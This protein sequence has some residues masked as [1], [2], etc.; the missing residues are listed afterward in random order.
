MCLRMH[1]QRFIQRL[2][3]TA[4]AWA[5]PLSQFLSQ[6]SVRLFI[7]QL[8]SMWEVQE[9]RKKCMSCMLNLSYFSRG[10]GRKS[11]FSM[12]LLSVSTRS[13]FFFWVFA[14]SLGCGCWKEAL[15]PSMWSWNTS[16]CSN[17]HHPWLLLF[18]SQIKKTGPWCWCSRKGPDTREDYSLNSLNSSFSESP[19]AAPYWLI[20]FLLL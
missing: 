18:M 5:L 13:L 1:I 10:G 11:T 4:V 15:L 16:R 12:C 7:S 14:G 20:P 19:P 6:R 17:C 3:L 8:K 9:G 2:I